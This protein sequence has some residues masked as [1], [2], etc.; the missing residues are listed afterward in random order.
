MIVETCPVCGSDLL[1][2]IITTYPPIPTWNCPKCGW[3]YEYREE[4]KRV[5]F[6]PPK[7]EA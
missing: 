2:I 6:T 1:H 3:N 4:I 5:P 7:E